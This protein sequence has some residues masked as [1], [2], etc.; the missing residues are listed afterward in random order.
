MIHGGRNDYQYSRYK[1]VAL[2][3]IHLLDLGSLT[4]VKL[5]VY[6]DVPSG[7]WGH[8]MAASINTVILFGGMNLQSFCEAKL[9]EFR[10]GK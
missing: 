7:R 8:S 4:W 10:I 1:D 3:D 5:A 2:N 6:G 9:F